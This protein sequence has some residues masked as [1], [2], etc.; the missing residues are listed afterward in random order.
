MKCSKLSHKVRGS[1]RREG[2]K[3]AAAADGPDRITVRTSHNQNPPSI[4]QCTSKLFPNIASIKQRTSSWTTPLPSIDTFHLPLLYGT[5]M[6]LEVLRPAPGEGISTRLGVPPVGRVLQ[7]AP[8]GKAWFGLGH[9]FTS[10][11]LD[12]RF[13][14]RRPIFSRF[15]SKKEPFQRFFFGR[16]KNSDRLRRLRRGGTVSLDLDRYKSIPVGAMEEEQKD[17]SYWISYGRQI[18]REQNQVQLT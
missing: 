15:F 7:G 3:G 10:S 18:E 9:V 13:H 11:R 5:L 2:Q 16:K 8:V 17:P 4:K 6:L 14:G 12:A 1:S